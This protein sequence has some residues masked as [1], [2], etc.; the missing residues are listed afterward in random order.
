M[1]YMLHVSEPKYY[2]FFSVER[3]LYSQ[4]IRIQKKREVNFQKSYFVKNNTRL[5]SARQFCRKHIKLFEEYPTSRDLVACWG[6]TNYKINVTF[7]SRVL[8]KDDA[9]VKSKLKFNCFGIP[10]ASKETNS[11]NTDICLVK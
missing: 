5:D 6:F 11:V 3:S 8:C 9:N 10:V 4:K 1:F 7:S 2:D